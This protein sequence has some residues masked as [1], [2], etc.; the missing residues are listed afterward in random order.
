MS[1]LR[2]HY[3]DWNPW[4]FATIGMGL[5][6]STA[7]ITG[8]VVANYTGSQKTSSPILDQA[9]PDQPASTGQPPP[10]PGQAMNAV[11]PPPPPARE[12]APA[13]PAPP[14]AERR[15]HV[16]PATADINACNRYAST[17]TQGKTQETLTDALIGGALGAGLGAAGGAIAGGGS[18]AG[19]GAGIGALVGAAGGTIYGLNET[20]QR[21]ARAAQA[22][23]TCMKRRGYSD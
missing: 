6:L 14:P 16:Q 8:V 3:P 18:G 10:V 13:V 15:A 21:D 20:N 12:V 4:K 7:L 22:Y 1:Q 19:K 11:P 9:A 17:A 2:L 23:R 5:V